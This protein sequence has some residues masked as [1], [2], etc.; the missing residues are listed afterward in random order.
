VI[1]EVDHELRRFY[2]EADDA[3]AVF[4]LKVRRFARARV[5]LRTVMPDLATPLRLIPRQRLVDELRLL[6][7]LVVKCA[8]MPIIP[9]MRRMEFLLELSQVSDELGDHGL[10]LLA[11]SE[12][13]AL[14]AGSAS[15]SYQS[16][17][18]VLSPLRSHPFLATVNRHIRARCT[19]AARGESLSFTR[20]DRQAAHRARA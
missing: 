5:S 9:K 13:I 7:P 19:L 15:L 12:L 20:R 16:Q 1:D 3:V 17:R 14:F 11:M 18:M 10:A 4:R 6:R 8:C 2:E